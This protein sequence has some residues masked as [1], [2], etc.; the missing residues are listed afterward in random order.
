M[1]VFK[2]IISLTLFITDRMVHLAGHNLPPGSNNHKPNLETEN[3]KTSF[4]STVGFSDSKYY[5]RKCYST[6]ESS[7]NQSLHEDGVVPCK[8]NASAFLQS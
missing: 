3:L 7:G 8:C 2:A 1:D 4:L 6:S 5:R